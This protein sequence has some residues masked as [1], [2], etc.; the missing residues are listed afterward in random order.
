MMQPIMHYSIPETRDLKDDKG[1]YMGYS[2]HI[3]GVLH[4]CVRYRQLHDLHER[5]SRAFGQS[6]LPPF[7]PKRLFPLTS[8]QLEERRARLEKYIQGLSQDPRVSNSS[9]FNNFW[10]STQRESRHMTL[11]N[12][13]LD[14]FLMNGSKLTQEV[15]TISPTHEV[16]QKV[17]ERLGLPERLYPHFGLFLMQKQEDGGVSMARYLQDCES[18][19]ITLKS[20]GNQ[21][22]IVIRKKTWDPG[23]ELEVLRD[24]VGLNLAY[25]QTVADIEHG[26]VPVPTDVQEA[27]ARLQSRGAKQQYMEDA[28]KQRFYGCIQF[29][30]CVCDHPEPGTRVTIRMSCKEMIMWCAEKT[31]NAAAASPP[32][33]ETVFRVTRIKCWRIT[34]KPKPLPDETEDERIPTDPE[35]KEMELELAFEYLVAKDELQWVR[36]TSPQA[37]LMSLCL[38]SMVQEIFQTQHKNH[39]DH[40]TDGGESSRNGMRVSSSLS[41]LSGKIKGRTPSQPEVQNSVFNNIGDDDL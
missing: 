14:V 17:C 40:P 15:S 41:W 5:L 24:P 39:S 9:L 19:Y 26:W 31:C 27:L 21:C 29:D 12:V 22:R 34:T 37:V 32:I 23:I 33:R 25:M 28:R 35:T 3:N 1:S 16:H 7:P 2:F 4:S 30:P 10:V 13:S 6:T 11:E 36:I 8:Q 38:H 18:P 20:F